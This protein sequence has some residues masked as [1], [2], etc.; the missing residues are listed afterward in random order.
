MSKSFVK[1]LRDQGKSNEAFEIQLRQMTL[2]ELIALKLE[3]SLQTANSPLY[4]FPIWRNIDYVI[5]EALLLFATSITK[6]KGEAS[7]ILGIDLQNYK[8]LLKKYDIKS[9]F[10]NNEEKD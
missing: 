4:G 7:R 3:L 1:V 6:S 9:I 2:E 8:K 10:E 5:R